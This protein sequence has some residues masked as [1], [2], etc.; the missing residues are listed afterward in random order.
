M[1]KLAPL[2]LYAGTDSGV[3]FKTSDG[4]KQLESRGFA[5]WPSQRSR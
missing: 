2:T 1:D 3:I 5:S 4:G